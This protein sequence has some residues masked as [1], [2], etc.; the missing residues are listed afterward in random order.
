M[1]PV[2]PKLKPA[3]RE[4]AA[5][6]LFPGSSASVIKIN[7]RLW[8]HDVGLYQLTKLFNWNI[9]LKSNSPNFYGRY[10]V[11]LTSTIMSTL[12][13]RTCVSEKFD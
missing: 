13:L 1:R 8:Y 5:A 6:Y 10:F 11:D 7:M 12:I 3:H 2:Q 4:I 9:S